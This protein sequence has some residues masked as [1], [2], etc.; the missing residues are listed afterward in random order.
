VEGYRI[1]QH[2][3]RCG[4]WIC[5]LARPIPD[6]WCSEVHGHVRDPSFTH[7]SRLELSTESNG[8]T[9]LVLLPSTGEVE[10]TR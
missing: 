10:R 2:G 5:D 3:D 7:I 6:A 4:R 9:L 8:M 1:S